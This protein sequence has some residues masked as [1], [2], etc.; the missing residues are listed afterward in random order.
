MWLEHLKTKDKKMSNTS[1]NK[2][3]TFRIAF[4][5]CC[6]SLTRSLYVLSGTTGVKPLCQTTF[7]LIGRAFIEIRFE[8]R[9][10]LS[11]SLLIKECGQLN[12]AATRASVSHRGVKRR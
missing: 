8:R 5:A 7:A 12:T 10:V 2:Y 11:F 6:F 1:L 4:F 3:I 9:L